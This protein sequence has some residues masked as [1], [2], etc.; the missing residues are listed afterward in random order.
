MPLFPLSA[1]VMLYRLWRLRR[2]FGLGFAILLLAGF[3]LD[4]PGRGWLVLLAAVGLALHL[5]SFPNGAQENLALAM[6]MGAMMLVQ[7]ALPDLALWLPAHLGQGAGLLQGVQSG[8]VFALMWV[9]FLGVIRCLVYLGPKGRYRFRAQGVLPCSPAVALQQ[10]GIRPGIRRGRM[11][12]GQADARGLFGVAVALG[13]DRVA[14]ATGYVLLCENDRHGVL[15]FLPDGGMAVSLLVARAVPDGSIL[16][17]AEMV[18]DMTPGMGFIH[19]LRD[20]QGDDLTEL[21]DRITGAAPRANAA[22]HHLSC[23]ALLRLVLSPAAPVAGSGP[24]GR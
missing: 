15:L 14:Q 9:A 12:C 3:G 17:M 23:L 22:A 5:V 24:L 8:V 18:D 10:A 2:V 13:P 11:I 7:G 6:G 16:Q 1:D 19:W 4:M 20:Q 21:A